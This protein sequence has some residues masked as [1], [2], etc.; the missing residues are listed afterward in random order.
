MEPDPKSKNQASPAPGGEQGERRKRRK[1]RRVPVTQGSQGA[2]VVM[3]QSEPRRRRRSSTRTQVDEKPRVPRVKIPSKWKLRVPAHVIVT[4][5]ILGPILM[6]IA[7]TFIIGVHNGND[8]RER[9]NSELAARSGAST[10]IEY[11]GMS[12]TQGSA[13][14]VTLDW[15]ASGLMSQYLEFGAVV[16]DQSPLDYVFGWPHVDLESKRGRADFVSTP[17]NP[18]FLSD[19]NPEFESQFGVKS[20]RCDSLDVVVDGRRAIQSAKGF[21]RWAGLNRRFLV[22]GGILDKEILEGYS[23]EQAM[24]ES[25]EGEE[26]VNA[27]FR[28][29]SDRAKVIVKGR[30]FNDSGSLGAWDIQMDQLPS[31]DVFSDQLQQWVQL[32]IDSAVGKFQISGD[33]LD[34]DG[35][36][37][38]WPKRIDLKLNIQAHRIDFSSLDCFNSLSSLLRKNSYRRPFFISPPA[39]QFSRSGQVQTLSGIELSTI[40]GLMVKGALQ[41]D[42]KKVTGNLEIGLP[43]RYAS[44]LKKHFIDGAFAKVERGHLWQTVKIWT[45]KSTV[46]DDLEHYLRSEQRRL[47]GYSIPA[48]N[49]PIIESEKARVP[50][51]QSQAEMEDAFNALIGD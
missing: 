46:R 15:S 7:W 30:L 28:G 8:F 18:R 1:K 11:L 42:G 24:V 12:P 26:F 43:R 44:E 38:P 22:S 13:Q 29:A 10:S 34:D 45:D 48:E 49:V 51:P 35:R 3:P 27:I 31:S 9:L 21:W 25:R 23:L 14:K 50:A 41:C 19:G 36:R 6:A 37:V 33:P 20:M 17:K 2:Q 5:C 4:S 39:M 47:D 32:D 16:F 40:E